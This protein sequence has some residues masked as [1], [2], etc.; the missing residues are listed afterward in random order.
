[1]TFLARGRHRLGWVRN[2]ALAER[3]ELQRLRH[4]LKATR[5]LPLALFRGEL[6]RGALDRAEFE[7]GGRP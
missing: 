1:M 3:R 2:Y 6:A 5:M 4:R 7:L